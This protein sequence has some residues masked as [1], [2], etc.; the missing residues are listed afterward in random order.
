MLSAFFKE[1]SANNISDFQSNYAQLTAEEQ[2]NL[3]PVVQ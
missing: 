3:A 2:R 1:V